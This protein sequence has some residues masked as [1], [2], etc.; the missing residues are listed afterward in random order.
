LIDGNDDDDDDVI[1][2]DD[3]IGDADNVDDAENEQQDGKKGEEYIEP[4]G[5]DFELIP[6]SKFCYAVLTGQ[7]LICYEK[8]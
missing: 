1:D 7:V 6:L 4:F 3:A 8:L 5:E 2:D